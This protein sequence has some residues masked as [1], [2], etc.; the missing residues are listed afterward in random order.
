[1][2]LHYGHNY[3]CLSPLGSVKEST[4]HEQQKPLLCHSLF[5]Y[6]SV[7]RTSRSQLLPALLEIQGGRLLGCW[8]KGNV[9]VVLVIIK[10]S[11]YLR[12]ILIYSGC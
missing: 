9:T 11:G 1:M 7:P 3:K 5:L 2:A 6:Q 12:G 4:E 10:V 8:E